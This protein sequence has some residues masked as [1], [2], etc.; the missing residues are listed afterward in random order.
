MAVHRSALFLLLLLLAGYS[1]PAT[2]YYVSATGSDAH[3]GTSPQQAWA[4]L[5]KANATRFYPGDSLLFEGGSRFEGGLYFG[6]DTRGTAS[7]PIVISSYPGADGARRA[8][9][10]SGNESGLQAYNT[11][12]FHISQLVFE[13]SGRT[14]NG[15]SGI[16]F[17]M[18]LPATRLTYLHI[19]SVE[20]WGY[21]EAGIMIGSW[22]GSSGFED[23]RITYTLAHDNGEAGITTYAEAVLGHARVY[24]GY[25]KAY[26]NSGKPDKTNSHSGSGIMLGGVEEGLIE[27]C[28]AYNNGWL[29]AWQGGGPVGIWGY[30]SHKLIIQYNESHHNRTGTAKDGGGFDIDGGCT[31]CTLQ[32]NYSHDNDGPGYLIAQY[33]DAP[34]L[35]GAVIRYN[36]SENDARKNGYGGIH[37]WSSGA[38][39]G[40]QDAQIY[41]NTVYMTPSDKGTPRALFVQSGGV[42]GVQIRNNLLV[43]SGGL[44][45]VYVD[46][47]TDVRFEGN[48]YWA[49]SGNFKVNWGGT[50]HT[51]LANWRQ[52]TGQEQKGGTALGHTLDPR[53]KAPGGGLNFPVAGQLYLLTGYELAED[54]PLADKGLDL[55]K[56]FG[57]DIGLQDFWGNSLQGRGKLSI[58]AYQPTP[59]LRACLQ[60]GRTMLQQ[61]D[62]P[63]GGTYS[64]KGVV[65]GAYFDPA[66]AGAGQHPITYTFTN[67][68]GRQQQK[69]LSVRVLKATTTAWTGQSGASASWFDAQNW[70]SCVPGLA[71]DAQ[72]PEGAQPLFEPGMP[73]Q[74]RDL[75]GQEVLSLPEGAQLEIAGQ[76]SGERLEAA[77]AGVRFSGSAGQPIPEGVYGSLEVK[78]SG[79]K[80][81]AGPVRILQTLR[82]GNSPLALGDADLQL[83]A[84]A[85]LEGAS[86]SSYLIT[87]GEGALVLEGIGE[88]ASALFP[89]GTE[90]GYAPALLTN[91]GQADAYSLRVEE[92]V[93]S[94][95]S[96]GNP[97]EQEGVDHTWHLSEGLKGGSDVQ[98]E[99]YWQQSDE[100]ELFER[101][102]SYISHFEEGSWS[103][104][105]T[106]AGF[107]REQNAE[108]FYS[109][110][111]EG[112]SSF[113][114]FAIRNR[115]V[116]LPVALGDFQVQAQGGDAL[117]SWFTYSEKDNRGFEVE[118]STDGS[119]Y[120]SLGFVAS[121]QPTTQQQQH[122]SFSD[123]ESA[124]TGTRYYR[125]RQL[126]LDGASSY[127]PVRMLRF[128][129][130]QQALGAYPNPFGNRLSLELQAATAEEAQISLIDTW[131]RQ[132]YSRSF[133][134]QPGL[135]AVSL[136]LQT[137]T[138]PG[139]YVLRASWGG[140]LQ[141]LKVVKR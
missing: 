129:G 66:L 36:I 64:G 125:L 10:Y 134:L 105:D 3:S 16:D 12:G 112:I 93:L 43:T 137:V 27:Y 8:T 7:Q 75:Q 40:I 80:T 60:G 140:Q 127:S 34:P 2:T 131:G 28:E 23:I 50:L 120:R 67:P 92:G 108:G 22:N 39:G 38:N 52:R 26:N 48:N 17:Y 109:I 51:S 141:Q 77:G 13:G 32:Y 20:V 87:S 44:E 5:Q 95:G 101:A 94:S 82:L 117:L 55:I 79:L 29:N 25:S 21:R 111:L 30:S 138:N 72:L 89:I 76:Y 78:G 6:S 139:V 96:W 62:V 132:V 14:R 106:R 122:Y 71:I 98:L 33:P 116:P 53:L 1:L 124:K 97:L 99:L 46:K 24:V 56:D 102:R 91:S 100:Q 110:R 136:D 88:G 42:K 19:D 114:P 59:L 47:L 61:E 90:Q 115:P 45:L 121:R 18:D 84:A 35:K 54:S 85:T 133:P 118:V 119:R 49:G 74:V 126:D 57:L 128:G 15:S 86:A 113:S 81:L 135:N 104:P 41:N 73:A 69:T 4:S 68:Q 63:P 123:T 107:A 9:L 130:L 58:G 65:E 70:S 83:A 37:L 11:A 31:D 103:E